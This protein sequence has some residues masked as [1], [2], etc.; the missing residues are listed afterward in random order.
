VGRARGTQVAD[1]RGGAEGVRPILVVVGLALAFLAALLAVWTSGRT[2]EWYR[3]VAGFQGLPPLVAALYGLRRL[4]ARRRRA[5]AAAGNRYVAGLAVLVLGLLC[6]AAAEFG[7]LAYGLFADALPLYPSWLDLGAVA[8]IV[9]WAA[10]VFVT[11]E[12]FVDGDGR[13][14]DFLKAVND[15]S[16]M[17]AIF[18]G[19]NVGLLAAFHG[20][21]LRGL[22]A[23]DAGSRAVGYALDA[24]FT[25]TD[26]F[27]LWTTARLVHGEPG[28]AMVRGR[29]ALILVAVGL[30]LL[31]AADLV[32]TL[33]YAVGERR[34]EFLFSPYYG[35][36]PDFAYT[37][38]IACMSVAAQLYPTDPPV[39]ATDER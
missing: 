35:I 33:N 32:A 12:G 34:G 37:A 13:R 10:V 2:A 17:L 30:G 16:R 21:D 18:F 15:D 31:Y 28:R 14:F 4:A 8:S 6:W 22:V 25:T 20:A 29:A 19:A 1:R 5:A 23:P 7:L 9:C 3:Y 26:L 38:Y 36:V 11:F 39:F 24:F 27:L